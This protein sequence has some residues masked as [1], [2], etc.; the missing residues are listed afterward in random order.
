MNS[1]P[2]CFQVCCYSAFNMTIVNENMNRQQE[3][4]EV[5]EIYYNPLNRAEGEAI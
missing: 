4:C 1:L 3:P 5:I 2:C